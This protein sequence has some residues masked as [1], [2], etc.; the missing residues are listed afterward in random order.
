M[1]WLDVAA[2]VK[3]SGNFHPLT[4]IQCEPPE[5]TPLSGSEWQMWAVGQLAVVA[6][7]ESWQP[8]RYRYT[9]QDR[10]DEG[11]PCAVHANGLWDLDTHAARSE[12]RR[13]DLER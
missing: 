7:Y 6:E 10:D 9:V 8:G 11:R 5:P 2:A 12:E 13:S 1:I 4:E 3:L